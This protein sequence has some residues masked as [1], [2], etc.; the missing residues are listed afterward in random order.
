MQSLF[1]IFAS[2]TGVPVIVDL[3]CEFVY[4]FECNSPEADV[5]TG[6]RFFGVQKQGSFGAAAPRQDLFKQALKGTRL[7]FH[8]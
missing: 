7:R 8:D 1:V 4:N 3:V 5:N 6:Y 2:P